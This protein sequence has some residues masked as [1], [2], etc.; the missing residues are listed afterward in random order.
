MEYDE[1]ADDKPQL[2]NWEKDY[3]KSWELVTE[4]EKGL[5]ALASERKKRFRVIIDNIHKC[6]VEGEP[7]KMNWS[8]YEKEWPDMY[9]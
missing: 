6:F 8:I 3:E 9:L 4:D 2:F 5:R 1:D 7:N